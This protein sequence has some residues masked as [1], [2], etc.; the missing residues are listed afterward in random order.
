LLLLPLPFKRCGWQ[1]WVLTVLVSLSVMEFV[2]HQSLNLSDAV[3]EPPVM[4][5][6][7]LLCF[8][9]RVAECSVPSKKQKQS[10]N[11]QYALV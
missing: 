11:M 5:L 8:V 10:S 9:R 7:H 4:L 6:L 1:G 3:A 2:R